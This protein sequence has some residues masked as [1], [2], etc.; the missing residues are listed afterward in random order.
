MRSHGIRRAAAVFTE[1][2]TSGGILL[3]Q[4]AKKRAVAALTYSVSLWARPPPAKGGRWP[5]RTARA[6]ATGSDLAEADGVARQACVTRL[7]EELKRLNLPVVAQAGRS[8]GG[9]DRLEYL[10]AGKRTGT[11]R[12]RLGDWARF[13]KWLAGQSRADGFPAARDLLDYQEARAAEPCGKTVLQSALEAV[14]LFETVGGVPPDQR[15]SQDSLVLASVS[16]LSAGLA[17][18]RPEDRRQAHYLPVKLVTRLEAMVMDE[19]QPK[20][21]RYYAWLRLLKLWAALRFDDLRWVEPARV[22]MTASGL[23]LSLTRTKVTGP[24]KKIGTLVAFV[25]FDAFFTAPGWLSDGFNLRR[26]AF[27]NIRCMFPLPTAD[28]D[29][30]RGHPGRVLGRFLGVAGALRELA[31]ADARG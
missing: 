16:E 22:E 31:R 6:R 21:R 2:R 10:A 3:E 15:I 20:Y 17:S 12:R 26:E 23:R 29:G 27:A 7:V 18:K 11:L 1:T 25:C 13:C 28:L 19:E 8:L 30:G 24:G 9:G 5:T 14:I 4:A